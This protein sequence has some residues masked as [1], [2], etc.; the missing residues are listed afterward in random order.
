MQ[1][2]DTP[3][4]FRFAFDSIRLPAFYL[5]AEHGENF[6]A[7]FVESEASEKSEIG[8]DDKAGNWIID[9]FDNLLGSEWVTLEN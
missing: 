8:S 5:V 9:H 3:G 2:T 6:Q 1:T 7:I 4:S